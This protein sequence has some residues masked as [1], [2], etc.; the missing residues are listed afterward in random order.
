MG[1][2]RVDFDVNPGV[3]RVLDQAQKRE[4]NQR[5]QRQRARPARGRERAKK[6][7]RLD[8]RVARVLDL[9]ATAEGTSPAGVVD[10]FVARAAQL[11]AEGVLTFDDVL[12]ASRSPGQDWLVS[13]PGLDELEAR[14]IDLVDNGGPFDQAHGGG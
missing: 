4:A 9:I 8:P 13:V 14:L 6:T 1:R 7:Y 5:R 12:Q 10:W 3:A 11:Y 2:Q